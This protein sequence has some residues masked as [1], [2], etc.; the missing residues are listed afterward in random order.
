MTVSLRKYATIRGYILYSSTIG[1][2]IPC[3]SPLASTFSVIPSPAQ[4]IT[5]SMIP[6]APTSSETS[7]T[8]SSAEAPLPSS[9]FAT[10]TLAPATTTSISNNAYWSVPYPVQPPAGSK[11]STGDIVAISLVSVL[12]A[13]AIPLWL[14]GR[15]LR[16]GRKSDLEK[17]R[18]TVVWIAPLEIEALA[19]KY[20]L[21]H[22]HD[23]K[24]TSGR[25]DDYIYTAG[26]I[27]GHSVII[28]T[29]PAGHSYGVG[30][31][32]SL[33][34][35]V[36][37]KF[38]NLWFGLLV[39]VA[40]G[41]PDLSKV[42]PRDIRLGDVLVGLG[43]NGNTG[44]VS[45]GF[46]KETVEEFQ[47]TGA[48]AR[49][50]MLVSAAIGAIKLSGPNQWSVFRQ[51]YESIQ[52]KEHND[53]G[54]FADPGQAKD[55]LYVRANEGS[56]VSLPVQ[57]QPRPPDERIKVWYGKIGSGD[58][59]MKNAQKRDELRAK[60]DIIGLE[61]EAAG[62]MDTIP[63]GVIRGV[64]DYADEHKNEEWQPYAAAMA[65]AYAKALLYRITPDPEINGS[66]GTSP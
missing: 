41:L 46:G 59:L 14:L 51:Y 44:I 65:A 5:S 15:R 17:Q 12:G 22:V 49:T 16:Q 33:A 52:D 32:A 19:A 60:Y 4:T 57:R 58:K 23:V 28:A 42:S 36:K 37:A 10:A 13:S 64:C 54:T 29:F 6:I 24:F 26:D 47:L 40:A 39:G 38:P 56:P 27:N 8:D 50:A 7:T 61:M 45:Y 34:R 21:D 63:V 66:E 1:G 3:Y 30:S 35:D 20:M 11:I 53:N 55:H 25:G 31:A 43:Q 18:Y 62:V 48:E 9:T 2:I